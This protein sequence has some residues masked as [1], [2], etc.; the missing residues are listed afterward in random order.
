MPA[1]GGRQLGGLM[2][3]GVRTAALPVFLALTLP[4]ASLFIAATAGAAAREV[5]VGTYD[6]PPLVSLD[7]HGNPVGLYID[8]QQVAARNAWHL[9]CVN[10]S[11]SENL[12][13]LRSSKIDFVVLDMAQTQRRLFYV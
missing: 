9:T 7:A 8:V 13:W 4:T 6:D 11:W 5:R 1:R 2:R 10:G 12:A 3:S